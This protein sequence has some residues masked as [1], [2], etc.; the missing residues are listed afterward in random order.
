MTGVMAMLGD[1]ARKLLRIVYNYSTLVGKP[2]TLEELVR[3]SG[4]T[5]GQVKMAL[6]VLSMEKYITWEEEKPHK[7]VVL[8]GWERNP[9]HWWEK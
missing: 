1:N 9:E 7:I 4:R 6:R 8:Q 5:R 2:P 3:K